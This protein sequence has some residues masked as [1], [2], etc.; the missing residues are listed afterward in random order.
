MKVVLG[1]KGELSISK[2]CC[3]LLRLYIDSSQDSVEESWS[4]WEEDEGL[5][6]RILVIF[7]FGKKD[8]KTKKRTSV[9]SSNWQE[10]LQWEDYPTLRTIAS[11]FDIFRSW[12]PK[13]TF[14]FS[15]FYCNSSVFFRR[16]LSHFLSYSSKSRNSW[17]FRTA[18]ELEQ[19]FILLS[20]YPSNISNLST[21]RT[22]HCH[23]LDGTASTRLM[24]SKWFTHPPR[25]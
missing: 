6:W 11:G 5:Y 18:L 10:R 4:E 19:P 2:V 20:P 16:C 12:N 14:I 9:W 25:K 23:L 17:Q 1:V 21:N 15:C 3:A 13:L 24:L 8:N 22:T 7:S